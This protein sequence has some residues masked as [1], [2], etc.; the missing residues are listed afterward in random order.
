MKYLNY[1]KMINKIILLG[2]AMLSIG[3]KESSG[4]DKGIIVG[5]NAYVYKSN[6]YN[7]ADFKA[8]DNYMKYIRSY[9]RS[10]GFELGYQLNPQWQIAI[11]PNFASMNQGYE[12][13]EYY[14]F[15]EPQIKREISTKLNYFKLPITLSRYFGTKKLKL[16]SH[17]GCTIWRLRSYTD[18]YKVANLPG[19]EVKFVQTID[20][21][22]Y[23]YEIPNSLYKS[24]IVL[25]ENLYTNIALGIHGGLGASYNFTQKIQAFANIRIEYSFSGIENKD[26]LEIVEATP[27]SLKGRKLAPFGSSTVKYFDSDYTAPDPNAERLP[28]H[29][30]NMGICIGFRYLIRQ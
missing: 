11:E 14:Q 9:G 1:L 26:S 19:N 6:L 16:Q 13:L 18:E 4:Q 8:D 24:D 5:L 21:K 10:Y 7:K 3:L 25:S 28:T 30:F 22:S 2:I 20:D 27:S 29:L 15:S 23:H 12:G 17:I